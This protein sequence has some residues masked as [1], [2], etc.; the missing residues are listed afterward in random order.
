MFDLLLHHVEEF[1]V[2]L[3]SPDFVQDKLHG[4]N[5]IHPMDELAQDPDLL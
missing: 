3:G 2:G 1:G 5:F 4:F